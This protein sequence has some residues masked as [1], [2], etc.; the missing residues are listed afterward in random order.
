MS[1]EKLSTQE[2]KE[3]LNHTESKEHLEKIRSNLEKNAERAKNNGE[4]EVIEARKTIDSEAISGRE[5][6][7]DSSEKKSQQSITK[8][9]KTRT[10]KMTMKRAQSQMSGPSRAFSKFIHN[11][12]VEKTS[13]TVGATVA[14]PSGILGAGLL[15][16]IGISIILYYA[17]KNGF[18]IDNPYSLT[19]ILI[20]GGWILGVVVELLYKSLKKVLS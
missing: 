8:A 16:F 13:E 15:G 19:V 17:R 5:T 6:M 7:P 14:R 3:H 4:K 2:N 9:E 11:Q 12:F 18:A 1:K 20:V 10:Y